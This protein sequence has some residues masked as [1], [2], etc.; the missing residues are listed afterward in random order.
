VL[1]A[2]KRLNIFFG[3]VAL[4]FNHRNILNLLGKSDAVKV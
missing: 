1:D 3:V 4:F 2:L